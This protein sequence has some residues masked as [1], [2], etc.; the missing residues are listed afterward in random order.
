VLCLAWVSPAY[1][2]EGEGDAS[3]APALQRQA[4][5][6]FLFGRPR[7]SLGIRG[8]WTVARAGSDWYD[9]VSDTLTVERSDFRA[10]GVAGDVGVALTPRLDLVFG[11]DYAGRTTPSE[12]RNFVDNDRLPILQATELR[13]ASIT[14]GVRFALASRGR[15]V[16]SFAWIPHRWVPYVGGGAG[17]LYYQV[18][19]SGDWVDI[20]D[21]S[22]FPDVFESNGWTPVA[23]LNGGLD[24]QLVRRLYLTFDARYQWA[25]SELDGVWQGF[26]PLDLASVRL[27]TG[28]NIVF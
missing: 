18:R 13:Q 7:A 4:A 22:I 8:S 15:E 23:Y 14:G 2:G 17:V 19:Q 10:A 26:E 11:A 9:F 27:S 3:A 12:Y 20:Q 21:L 24:L 6:D 16:G 1:A 5:P 28:I 25:E